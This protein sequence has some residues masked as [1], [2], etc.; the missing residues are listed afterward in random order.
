MRKRGTEPYLAHNTCPDLIRDADYRYRRHVI[1]VTS[2][3]LDWESIRSRPRDG[4]STSYRLSK[5]WV[6]GCLGGQVGGWVWWLGW[7]APKIFVPAP[8]I[9]IVVHQARLMMFLLKMVD[10]SISFLS[11]ST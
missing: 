3:R 8:S 5:G 11:L 7:F 9:L 4:L 10:Y 2:I 6:A 1:E